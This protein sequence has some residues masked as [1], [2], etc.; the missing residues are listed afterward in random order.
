MAGACNICNFYFFYNTNL[1][2]SIFH[3]SI[4]RE[5]VYNRDAKENTKFLFWFPCLL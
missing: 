2:A 1:K 3:A 5:K 4:Y